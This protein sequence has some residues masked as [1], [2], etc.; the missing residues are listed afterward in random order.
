MSSKSIFMR[1]LY[2]LWPPF[3]TAGIH[4]ERISDDLREVDVRMGLHL[5]NKNIM[6]TQFGGS[7]YAMTDPFYMAMLIEALGK[8]FIV[9]DKAASIR[10]KKPG[11]GTVYAKFKL[12]EAQIQEVRDQATKLDKYEPVFTV[13]VT[14][15]TGLV[16]CEVDKTIYVR[17][18]SKL[19]GGS[20]PK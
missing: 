15:K 17:H 10:F 9:W 14:D 6:G 19:R 8:D 12:T 13:Q 5:W 16:I 11:R 1:T 7:L 2:N 18:Q 4:I 20:P 3:L